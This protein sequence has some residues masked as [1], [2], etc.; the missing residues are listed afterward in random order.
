[1]PRISLYTEIDAPIERC[2]KLSPSV[3]LHQQSTAKTGERV[4]GGVMSGIMKQGETV[5]WRAKH[6]GVWQKLTTKIVETREPTFFSDAMVKGAFRSMYH[7]HHFE[8]RNGKCFM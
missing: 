8:D 4:V 6:F 1:M 3:D 5:T 2:Y 7:E